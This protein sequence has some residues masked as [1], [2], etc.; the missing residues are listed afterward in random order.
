MAGVGAINAASLAPPRPNKQSIQAV[1][2][3]TLG[4]EKK[5]S[6]LFY[7]P[8]TSLITYPSPFSVQYCARLH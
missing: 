8:L 4:G 7:H 2:F 1:A 6:H 5:K 3:P